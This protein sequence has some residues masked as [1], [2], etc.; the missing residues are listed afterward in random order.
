MMEIFNLCTGS[1]VFAGILILLS[2]RKVALQ[3]LEDG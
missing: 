1:I 3:V 2:L